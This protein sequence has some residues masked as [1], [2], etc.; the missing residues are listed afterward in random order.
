MELE[1]FVVNKGVNMFRRGDDQFVA[2]ALSCSGF[3]PRV[4]TASLL[5]RFEQI[6]PREA[7]HTNLL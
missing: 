3:S 6:P 5:I 2:E 7:A 4:S 1:A